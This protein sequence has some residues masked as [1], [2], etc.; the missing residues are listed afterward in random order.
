MKYFILIF[1]QAVCTTLLEFSGR[2]KD[3]ATQRVIVQELATILG[4]HCQDVAWCVEVV[5]PV[6]LTNPNPD[7]GIIKAL[8]QV[9]ER[10]NVHQ[11]SIYHHS[12][13][14]IHME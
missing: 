4:Q 1:I 13:I 2:I 11:D 8:I 10:G 6:M 3:E 12:L 9:I 14:L 7:K 5:S